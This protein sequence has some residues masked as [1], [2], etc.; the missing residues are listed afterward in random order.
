M[1]EF[2]DFPA[3]APDAQ[4]QALVAEMVAQLRAAVPFEDLPT[5]GADA[6]A[7]LF[8]HQNVRYNASQRLVWAG[9]ASRPDCRPLSTLAKDAVPRRQLDSYKLTSTSSTPPAATRSRPTLAVTHPRATPAPNWTRA[10]TTR[11]RRA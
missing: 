5:L 10:R 1:E 2:E 9:G 8:E 6:T 3:D 11:P 4:Q 7:L